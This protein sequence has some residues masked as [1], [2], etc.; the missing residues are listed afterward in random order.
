MII[1]LVA[2]ECRSIR[3]SKI[4][5]LTCTDIVWLSWSSQASSHPALSSEDCNLQRWKLSIHLS[6]PFMAYSPSFKTQD[7]WR[8]QHWRCRMS[9]VSEIQLTPYLDLLMKEFEE[10]ELHL[11]LNNL[12]C[13]SL[14]LI[15]ANMI[16]SKDVCPKRKSTEQLVGPAVLYSKATPHLSGKSVSKAM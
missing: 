9:T 3:L 15:M 10:D 1:S 8:R 12:F 14:H 11:E 6:I 7:H 4:A 5:Y 16:R 13:S 2:R